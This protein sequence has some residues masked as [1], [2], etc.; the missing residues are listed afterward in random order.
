MDK[1]IMVDRGLEGSDVGRWIVSNV[2]MERD[3]LKEVLVYKFFLRVPKLLVVL[4]D[5]CVLVWVVVGSS[6][7]G[8]GGEELG[9]ESGGN[10]IGWRFDGKRWESSGWLQSGATGRR[11]LVDWGK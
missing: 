11:Y 10:S 1:D 7:A 8:R 2:A 3:K 5:D 6:G 9:K 4:V